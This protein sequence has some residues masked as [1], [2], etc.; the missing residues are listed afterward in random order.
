MR[1]LPITRAIESLA[2]T[3]PEVD[4]PNSGAALH[5]RVRV[6][7]RELATVNIAEVMTL[8]A[9]GGGFDSTSNDAITNPGSID[10]RCRWRD[11]S[12]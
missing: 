3:S 1:I 11:D 10:W 6:I 5:A 2:W 4:G 9:N 7:L 12:A 8:Q